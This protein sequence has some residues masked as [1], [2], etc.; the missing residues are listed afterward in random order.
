MLITVLGGCSGAAVPSVPPASAAASPTISQTAAPT[1][2][3]SVA[4]SSAA[5][6]TASGAGKLCAK[7]HEVCPIAAGTYSSAPF[8]HPFTFTIDG[9]DWTNDRAWPH[10]G[11]MTKG[12]TDSFLWASGITVGRVGDTDSP[13]GPTQQDFIDHLRKFTQFE[14]TATPVPVTVGGVSGLQV[15]VVATG[16]APGLFVFPEDAFNLSAGEKVRFIVLDK[17]GATVVLMVE[18]FKEATFDAF[19]TGVAQP[20]L[21]G[22]TW[23]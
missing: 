23:E 8:E 15:D 19:M 14:V 5:P 12:G 3:P 2:S 1:P 7:E 10:G 11:S 13:I 6:S 21:D 20:I 18:S 9:D 22:L 16:E 17:E 4:R